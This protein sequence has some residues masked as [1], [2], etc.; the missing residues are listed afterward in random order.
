MAPKCSLRSI[1]LCK[2]NANLNPASFP[3]ACSGTNVW[4]GNLPLSYSE[5]DF[6]SLMSTCGTITSLKLLKDK[7]SG[8]SEGIPSATSCMRWM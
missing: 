5:A 7:K 4:V 2:V 3:I 8:N 1:L 6:R